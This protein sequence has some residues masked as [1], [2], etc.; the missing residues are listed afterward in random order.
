MSDKMIDKIKALLAKADNTACTEEEAQA[1]NAKAHELMAKYNIERSQLETAEE[2]E[3]KRIHL[4]LM[5]QLRPWSKYVLQGITKLYY[6]TYF[7]QTVGRQHRITIIGEE[8]NVAVCHAIC[9][10]VLRSIQTAA[11]VSR[12]GRSFMTGA[13]IEV[14]RR[15]NEMFFATHSV[16]DGPTTPLQVGHNESA[17]ALKVIAVN[18]ARGNEDYIARIMGI[19]LRVKK[20][21]PAL[22]KDP[23]AFSRGVDHGSKVQLRRNLLG[24]G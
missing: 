8:Q 12:D 14:H 1:F 10:M 7:S 6:C 17:N 11:R 22:I 13:G 19:R 20:S 18:E 15:C 3:A 4:E 5:V 24:A 16:I 23:S 21:R 9:V 2:R